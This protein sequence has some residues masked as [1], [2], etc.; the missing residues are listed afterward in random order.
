M[1]GLIRTTIQSAPPI[2]AAIAGI[3]VPIVGV[4]PVFLAVVVLIGL[5][6]VIALVLPTLYVERSE[7]ALG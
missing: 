7:L 3:V 6:G 5:P 1:F 4:R 2:G